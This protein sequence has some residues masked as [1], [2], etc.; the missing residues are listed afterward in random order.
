MSPLRT[1][2]RKLHDA[3]ERLWPWQTGLTNS[4]VLTVLWMDSLTGLLFQSLRTYDGGLPPTELASRI[5]ALMKLAGSAFG[6]NE[7]PE[8][9][10]FGELTILNSKGEF[11][12]LF[13]AYQGKVPVWLRARAESVLKE[14]ESTFREEA[15]RNHQDGQF[16][17]SEA[18][19]S[20][21]L[22][23]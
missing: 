2:I 21:C 20:K 12:R 15:N 14:L 17:G 3:R 8:S 16:N 13:V 10:D 11:S 22:C 1:L 7:T 19:L 23:E 6:D 5:T 4:R 9:M 18:S